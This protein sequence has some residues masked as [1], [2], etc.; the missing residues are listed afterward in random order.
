MHDVSGLPCDSLPLRQAMGEN[1]LAALPELAT[2]L[3][4]EG[5]PDPLATKAVFFDVLGY[6]MVRLCP[7]LRII[8]HLVRHADSLTTRHEI[9]QDT[10][11][12]YSHARAKFLHSLPLLFVLT[13]LSLRGNLLPRP[14]SLLQIGGGALACAAAYILAVLAP[15]L[16]GVARVLALGESQLIRQACRTHVSAG[17]VQTRFALSWGFPPGFRLT[18]GNP[19]VWYSQHAIAFAMYIPAA[20]AGALIPSMLF[21]LEHRAALMGTALLLGGGA[22]VMTAVGLGSGFLLALWSCAAIL[23]A[24]SQPKVST[25]A[26]LCSKAF[27]SHAGLSGV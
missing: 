24:P 3:A 15:A 4:H 23:A 5:R 6:F 16:L 10:Q 11:V 27:T 9:R 2:Q 1:L 8:F 26:A 14:P 22:A 20:V 21:H 18:T 25:A 7:G 13:A 19:M 12:S 17:V